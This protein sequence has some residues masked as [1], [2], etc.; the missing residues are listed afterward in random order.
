MHT[1]QP[2]H[3]EKHVYRNWNDF[4]V[5][6][7][8]RGEWRQEYFER[9]SCFWIATEPAPR[10]DQAKFPWPWDRSGG[11][12]ANAPSN[13]WCVAQRGTLPSKIR[14]QAEHNSALSPQGKWFSAQ[15]Q[16]TLLVTS[17]TSTALPDSAVFLCWWI[18]LT[19]PVQSSSVW[20][21]SSVMC[22]GLNATLLL[23][24]VR[25]DLR[26]AHCRNLPPGY[27]ILEFLWLFP[28]RFYLLPSRDLQLP[29]NFFTSD[30]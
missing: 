18:Q 6:Y 9:E 26:T 8:C 15:S 22:G 21:I 16:Q 2:A 25:A 4:F 13:S 1:K 12:W 5:V 24:L 20:L 27:R 30:R 14:L 19:W 17:A 10:C 23:V 11:C 29:L 28:V 7:S 3:E